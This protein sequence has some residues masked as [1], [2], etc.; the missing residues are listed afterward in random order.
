MCWHSSSQTVPHMHLTEECTLSTGQYMKSQLLKLKK[1]FQKIVHIQAQSVGELYYLLFE[2]VF[3]N[4]FLGS[5]ITPC[6]ITP[7][8]WV[9]VFILY[10]LKQAYKMFPW[11][12]QFPWYDLSPPFSSPFI[13]FLLLRFKFSLH[14]AHCPFLTSVSYSHFQS[15]FC[16]ST[17]FTMVPFLPGFFRSI[18][19]YTQIQV[20]QRSASENP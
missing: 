12:F 9:C 14:F 19:L 11:P 18:R 13:I 3:K 15:S 6:H 5:T 10:I 16:L 20:S 17:S 2:F 1:V 7:F 4:L 8:K